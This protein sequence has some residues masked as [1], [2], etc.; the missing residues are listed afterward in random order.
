M[1]EQAARVTP[2]P[3]RARGSLVVREKVVRA[4]AEQAAANVPGVATRSS[5][6]I[7]GVLTRDLPA[8]TVRLYERGARISVSVGSTWPTPVAVLARDVRDRVALQVRELTGIAA[9]QVDVGVV[10]FVDDTAQV[11]RMA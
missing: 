9:T 8:A 7:A 6:G 11:R 3:D 4:V 5:A 2:P 10:A 1:P